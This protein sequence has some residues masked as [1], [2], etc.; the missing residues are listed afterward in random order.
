MGVAFGLFFVKTRRVW[1]L[2]IAHGLI[3]VVAFVGYAL[4]APHVNW[5]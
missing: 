1:P 4:V 2:V 3:D 5:L